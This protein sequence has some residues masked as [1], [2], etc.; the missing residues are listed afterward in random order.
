MDSAVR[1]FWLVLL[2]V[3]SPILRKSFN[4]LSFESGERVEKD[5]FTVQLG[6]HKSDSGIAGK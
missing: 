2:M 6:S 1:C 5:G 4:C 3:S